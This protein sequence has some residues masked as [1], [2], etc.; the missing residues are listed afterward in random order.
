MEINLAAGSKSIYIT[1]IYIYI[2][3]LIVKRDIIV[4]LR[5]RDSLYERLGNWMVNESVK[6]RTVQAL[7]LKQSLDSRNDL[8]R[9]LSFRV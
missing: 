9:G 2:Y 3:I 1:Y 4:G 5:W 6:I 7:S 8:V